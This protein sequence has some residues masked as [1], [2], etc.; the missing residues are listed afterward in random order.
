MNK[1]TLIVIFLLWG[2]TTTAQTAKV[3]SS[4]M[5]TL[6]IDPES[7]RGATV[8][9]FFDEIEYIPLETT[10]ESLFGKINQLKL[11]KNNYVIYDFDTKSV[12][13]FN[14][15]GKF[16]AKIN[17]TMLK[18]D[19]ESKEPTNFFGFRIINIDGQEQ[20]A[21]SAAKNIFFFDLNG[22]LIQKKLT[23]DYPVD[24]T[25]SF[26][27]ANRY[28]KASHLKIDGKDSTYYEISLFNNGNEIGNYLPIKRIKG[29]IYMP[30]SNTNISGVYNY[31]I[32]NKFF[33][34][35][36]YHFNIYEITPEKLS[37]AYRIILPAANSL[38]SDFLTN[39]IYNGQKMPFLQKNNQLAFGIGDTFKFGNHLFFK[40]RSMALNG[41]KNNALIY[42]LKTGE[43][44]S[45]KDLEPDKLSFYLPVTDAGA[46][47]DYTMNGMHLYSEG[48]LY[49]SYSSLAMFTFKEQS[50]GKN[51]QYNATLT[52]YFKTQ[53][54]KSNPVLIR[55]KPKTAN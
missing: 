53:S 49:T 29:D 4:S 14:K 1:L 32:E 17:A 50:T 27:N 19:E 39:E 24:R 41:S 5:V 54:R 36:P 34:T 35:S 52:D 42:N 25:Y 26:S 6:R 2:I 7:A 9:Q 46:Y 40:F 37:L 20:I 13:I 23:K 3:D 12:L 47:Y 38:P 55:L 21:I 48:Y 8:S 22:K 33:Y 10:S 15:A 45:I 18:S 30:G 44:T 43:L 16:V 51:P 11:T 28:A 31:G